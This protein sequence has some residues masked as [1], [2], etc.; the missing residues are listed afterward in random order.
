[1]NH[2]I[3]AGALV[4]HGGKVLLVRHRK[5]GSYDFWVAP[6]GGVQ[7]TESLA[8]AAQREVREETGLEVVA[9]RLVYV[10]EFY[11]P[12]TRHCK[13]WFSAR[14]VGGTL[15]W[16]APEAVSEHIVEAGWHTKEQVQSL[17]VFPLELQARYWQ[18]LASGFPGPHHLGLRKMAFW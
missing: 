18:D 11:Q 6:G 12:D 17:Q 3:S 16:E 15:N 13:F 10:E 4:E 14:L 7:G 2:R 9:D 8:E 5:E 1:M